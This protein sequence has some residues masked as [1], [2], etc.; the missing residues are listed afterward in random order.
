LIGILQ[1]CRAHHQDGGLQSRPASEVMHT[2]WKSNFQSRAE[3]NPKVIFRRFTH[4]RLSQI[5]GEKA[6]SN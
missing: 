3:F 1:K 4:C 6:S 2:P 5:T